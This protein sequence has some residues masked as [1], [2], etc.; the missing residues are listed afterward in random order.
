MENKFSVP[1]LLWIMLSLACIMVILYGLS[2]TLKKTNWAE[3]RQKKILLGTTLFI[4]GWAIV[5]SVL[6][7]KGFFADFSKLPPRPALALILPLPIV[8]FFAFSKAGT[9]LLQSVPAHW[10]VFMQAFRILVELLLWLAFRK[11]LLPVQMTFEAGNF[12][13][14]SGILA[15]PVGYILMKQKGTAR[16]TGIAYNII[17]M[18][19]LLNIL[20]IAVLSMP[21]QFRY[22]MNEPSNT[23]V[24]QF[25]FILLPGILVPIAYSVHILSLRQLL[26]KK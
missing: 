7:W 24:A 19:L 14:I 13:I 20:V 3:A 18:L 11:N 25:P 10:L 8:L 5:L 15:L 26:T 12:D 16:L 2:K 23:L 4:S 9:G 21:T 17:G 6:A 22:F 1:A